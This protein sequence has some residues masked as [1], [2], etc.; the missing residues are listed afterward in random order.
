VSWAEF[1]LC[2]LRSTWDYHLHAIE[3]ASWIDS[4]AARTQLLNPPAL[5]RWN[6]NKRYLAEVAERGIPVLP[7]LVVEPGEEIPFHDLDGRGWNDLV[8]KPLVGA[9]AWQIARC[10]LSTIAAVV[11]PELRRNGYIIQP[12]A[13][14]IEQGEY[15]LVFFDDSFSHAVLKKPHP[16]DYRTQPELGASQQ[17]VVPDA[18][19]IAAGAAVLSIL[20]EPAAYARI[21]GVLQDGR[22]LVMEAELI[23]PD[24][25][26][27]LNSSAADTFAALLLREANSHRTSAELG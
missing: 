22:F 15:S 11:S 7:L 9:S 3:F 5:L 27:R 23:E 6:S 10:S 25:F 20:P 24:L 26:F 4:V 17:V 16:G 19:L 12:F 8:V 2:V 14:E 18:S 1:D 21:D 13:A